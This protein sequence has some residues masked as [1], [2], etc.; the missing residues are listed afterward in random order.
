MEAKKK[1]V[2]KKMFGKGAK[3]VFAETDED[4]EREFAELKRLRKQYRD[5]GGSFS[6]KKQVIIMPKEK[7]KKDGSGKGTRA[8]KGRGGCKKQKTKGKGRGRQVIILSLQGKKEKIHPRDAEKT[9]NL[10][11]S[12][13]VL[14]EH[15]TGKKYNSPDMDRVLQEFEG[16]M[17]DIYIDRDLER[18]RK[19]AE[20]KSNK[21]G[22]F[23]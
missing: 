9:E 16:V 10:V 3:I 6:K 19:K 20:K 2:R 12:I 8:N 23:W 14:I 11:R 15:D 13:K 21:K 1:M 17:Y 4:S 18:E 5:C 7:P 22:R